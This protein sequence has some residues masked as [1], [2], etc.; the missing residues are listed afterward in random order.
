MYIYMAGC[1]A[2]LTVATK[3]SLEVVVESVCISSAPH[4]SDAGG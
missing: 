1:S 3:A 2:H 4:C